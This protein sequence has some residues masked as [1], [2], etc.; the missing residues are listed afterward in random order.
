MNEGTK[1]DE[2]KTQELKLQETKKPSNPRANAMPTNG[3]VLLVD[4]KLK[5][6]YQTAEEA[7]TA[8]A[9]LKQSYPVIK[10]EVYDAA[11]RISTEV[12][13]HS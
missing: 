2:K 6:Q 13:A 4:G 1:S 10:V 7:T 5:T 12:E 9:K 3:F 8:A 11:A